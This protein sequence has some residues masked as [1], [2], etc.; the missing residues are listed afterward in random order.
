MPVLELIE[1]FWRGAVGHES[2]T[3]HGDRRLDDRSHGSTPNPRRSCLIGAQVHGEY[4]PGRGSEGEDMSVYLPAK[5]GWVGLRELRGRWT[6]PACRTAK[7]GWIGGSD[8]SKNA[9]EYAA[10]HRLTKDRDG[11]LSTHQNAGCRPNQFAPIGEFAQG[12]HHAIGEYLHRR[13]AVCFW[14]SAAGND[15]HRE[16][17]GLRRCWRCHRM[18]G[19][20]PGFL[21][22][23]QCGQRLPSP[24][25]RKIKAVPCRGIFTAAMAVPSS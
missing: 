18:N 24:A 13:E 11:R 2:R 19:A 3:H 25:A 5:A 20:R 8:V 15:S 23:Q 6:N 4:A 1:N 9:G 12:D 10:L 16:G 22:E 21:A 17:L 7:N 14:K